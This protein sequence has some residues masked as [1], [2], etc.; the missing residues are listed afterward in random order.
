MDTDLRQQPVANERTD[1]TDCDIAYKPEASPSYD[2]ARQPTGNK[3]HHQIT[4]RLS[5]EIC[6]ISP[7]PL[8]L[9]PAR[10]GSRLY[11]TGTNGKF[12]FKSR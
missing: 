10:P 7:P 8:T 11:H 9:I 6:T 1:D 2:F 4:S 3:T 12:A 5:F